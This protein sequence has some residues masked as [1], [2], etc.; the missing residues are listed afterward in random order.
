MASTHVCPR[1]GSKQVRRSHR[2]GVMERLMTRV[3][4]MQLYRCAGCDH[5]F[6]GRRTGGPSERESIAS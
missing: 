4:P 2:R 5:R 6:A 3:L 1:C